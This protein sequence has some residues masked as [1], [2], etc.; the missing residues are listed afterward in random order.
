MTTYYVDFTLGDDAED[1]LSIANAWKTVTKVNASLFN[2]GDAVLFKAGETWPTELNIPS[3]GASGNHITFGTYG[4]TLGLTAWLTGGIDGQGHDYVTFYGLRITDG[5]LWIDQGESFF[6]FNYC[7][8]ENIDSYAFYGINAPTDIEF[9]NCVWIRNA[10]YHMA[11]NGAATIKARNCLFLSNRNTDEG[12]FSI[13]AGGNLDLDYCFISTYQAVSLTNVTDGGHNI[14]DVM[15]KITSYPPTPVVAPR[16]CLTFDDNYIDEFESMVNGIFSTYGIQATIFVEVGKLSAGQKI[17]CAAFVAAGHEVSNH[18]WSHEDLTAT[19]AFVVT[20]TNTSPT[21]DVD[22]A[23][24]TITLW[25]DE[26]GNRV[27]YDWSGDKTIADLKTAV[28]GKGWTITNSVQT[29][30][31]RQDILKLDCLSD[32]AGAQGVPYTTL[33]DITAPDYKFWDHEVND[34]QD[35]IEAFTGVR[36]TTMAYPYGFNSAGLITWLKAETTL[37]SARQV[38][39]APTT[40]F[41]VPIW[42]FIQR[43]PGWTTASTEEVVRTYSQKQYMTAIITPGYFLSYDHQTIAA[44]WLRYG[45]MIDEL[46]GLGATFLTYAQLVD[47]IESDH[48]VVGDNWTKNYDVTGGNYHLLADSPCI[49]EGLNVGLTKDMAGNLFIGLPDIGVF[50]YGEWNYKKYDILNYQKENQILDNWRDASAPSNPSPGMLFSDSY[51]DR[52]Y[53]HCGNNLWHELLSPLFQAAAVADA[54]G[55]GDLVARI[56]DVLARLRTIGLLET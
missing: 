12:P 14:F 18:S 37:K 34:A 55:A 44:H 17:Q 2:A 51:D 10:R 26:V 53:H 35:E 36:P 45:Y 16:F 21:V 5:R 19:E 3:S 7:I 22:I 27:T 23:T 39:G 13:G 30:K 4:Q 52:A 50:E 49:N 25:C 43:N 33:L 47:W 31:T 42:N 15:P 9:N 32:S 48:A 56:N 41:S 11:T 24:T 38:G 8:I 20:S 6:H 1:G 28:V 40:L 54:T 29:G 46:Q